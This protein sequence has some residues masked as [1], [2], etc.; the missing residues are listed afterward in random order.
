MTLLNPQLDPG[1]DNSTEGALVRLKSNSASL[2]SQELQTI[3][4]GLSKL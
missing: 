3:C 1:L 2:A 4:G